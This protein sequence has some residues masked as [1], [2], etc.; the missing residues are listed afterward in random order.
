MIAADES[1]AVAL[2]SRLLAADEGF[3][4]LDI[5]AAATS[6]ADSLAR[7]GLHAVDEVI[8]MS[9]GPSLRAHNGARTFGLVS[10]AFN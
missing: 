8:R 4:R 6:L 3:C 7:S 10:Q 1:I 9:R 5:P 2:S